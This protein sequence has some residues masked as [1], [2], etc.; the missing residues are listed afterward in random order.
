[1]GDSRMVDRPRRD[2]FVAL[3]WV[4]CEASSATPYRVLEAGPWWRAAAVDGA[5]A[6]R[7]PFDAATHCGVCSEVRERCRLLWGDDHEFE[8][9]AHAR[10]RKGTVDISPVVVEVKG[11][12]KPVPSGALHEPED[13]K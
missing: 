12:I 13:T 5:M 3:A 4:A 7:A 8:P 11:H 2:V 6:K 1:M 10:A 9:A